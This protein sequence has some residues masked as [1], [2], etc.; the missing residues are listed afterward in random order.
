MF[1]ATDAR[2]LCPLGRHVAT[3]QEWKD[4]ESALGMPA[5]DLDQLG[6]LRGI[7]QNVGG[8]LQAL[9]TW[10][11]PN[12]GANDLS[13]LGLTGS[14]LRT[15]SGSFSNLQNAGYWWTA[16]DSGTDALFRTILSSVEGV[17]RE[18]F[19]KPCGFCVRCVLD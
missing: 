15:S 5:S 18:A 7:A 19:P 9:Q 3:D 14:G 17:V 16:T 1:A 4:L 12:A 8:K 6:S 13:G 2:G 11:S 10:S